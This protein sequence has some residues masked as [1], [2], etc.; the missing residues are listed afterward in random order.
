MLTLT[1]ST[2]HSANFRGLRKKRNKRK[3]ETNL[4]VGQRRMAMIVT[5]ATVAAVL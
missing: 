5:V 3:S 4:T 2:A 1:L